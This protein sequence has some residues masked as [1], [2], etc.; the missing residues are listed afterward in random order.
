MIG[1]LYIIKNGDLYKIG[2]TKK[3]KVRMRQL[4]PDY[5]VA[6][7]YTSKYRELEKEFHKKYKDVRIPQ[8]EYFRL[9]RNQIREIKRT[10]HN[11]YY[12]ISITVEL[13][14]NS[15]LIVSSLFL[16]LIF[17]K[18]LTINNFNYVISSSILWMQWISLCI[19]LLSLFFKSKKY[20]SLFNEIKY[21]ASRSF[22]FILF[23]LIFRFIYI[24][25][26]FD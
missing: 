4:K 21:R 26:L 16:I 6:K 15:I 23:A 8:T 9:N 17:I 7:L 22:I 25:I 3:F 5:V 13:F 18:S 12:P 2:I 24:F 14:M 11:F 19:S 10:L 1:C 20:F